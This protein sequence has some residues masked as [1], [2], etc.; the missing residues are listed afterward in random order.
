M[1]ELGIH[2]LASFLRERAVNDSFP[3]AVVSGDLGEEGG[4]GR[5]QRYPVLAR[6]IGC[7]NCSIVAAIATRCVVADEHRC[8][9]VGILCGEVLRISMYAFLDPCNDQIS[10]ESGGL[11]Q[12][13]V[14]RS[15][16]G[17]LLHVV[18]PRFCGCTTI[19]GSNK[20][21]P[22]YGSN[23]G[24]ENDLQGNCRRS[25]ERVATGQHHCGAFNGRV[26][27]IWEIP[28]SFHK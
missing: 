22:R 19:R 15:D 12:Y 10:N 26:S 2:T 1:G 8:R 18:R 27:C 28:A 6:S 3:V 14:I 16:E 20:V 23:V 7:H 25:R 21:R 13:K 11:G 4:N 24:V 5:R 17:E 9:G